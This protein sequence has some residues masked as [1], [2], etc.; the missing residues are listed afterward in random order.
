MAGA[1]AAATPVEAALLAA[2]LEAARSARLAAEAAAAAA[3]AA[4]RAA[5][6]GQ[7]QHAGDAPPPHAPGTA[8]AATNGDGGG[9]AAS[10]SETEP[11][12]GVGSGERAA[13]LTH[14]DAAR[15]ESEEGVWVRVPV[16]T[17]TGA[18][19]ERADDG[20]D[21]EAEEEAEEEEALE[22]WRFVVPAGVSLARLHE[23]LL[24]SQALVAAAEEEKRVAADEVRGSWA[25][26]G[27]TSRVDVAP[28]P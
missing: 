24:E 13:T 20:D 10:D 28:M 25:W 5:A 4:L 8:S 7:P 18:G 9:A 27:W 22:E 16:G 21:E 14:P 15:G 19:K 1:A 2:A 3:Q 23:L 26:P 6:V 11:E 17:H 12:G